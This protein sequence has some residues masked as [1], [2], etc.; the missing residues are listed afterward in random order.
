MISFPDG[1]VVGTVDTGSTTFAGGMATTETIDAQSVPVQLHGIITG[2]DDT[3]D[4]WLQISLMPASAWDEVNGSWG[5]GVYAT[6]WNAPGGGGGLS[7]GLSLEADAVGGPFAYPM[8]DPADVAMEFTIT[9]TPT[10]ASGGTA[11]I[12]IV[13][14]TLSDDTSPLAYTGDYSQAVLA[15]QFLAGKENEVAT[16]TDVW[17]AQIPEPSAG[18]IVAGGVVLLALRRR[19]HA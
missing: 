9:M 6:T 11:T 15:I 1:S 17:A 12:E 19:R 16:F 18:V 5:V 10:D 3:S 7:D 8:E 2:I 13:G 4:S 14:H